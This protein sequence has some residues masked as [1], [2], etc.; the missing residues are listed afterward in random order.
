MLSRV[1]ESLFWMG[2][3]LERT[4]HLARYINVEYFS[5]LDGSNLQ[6]HDMA[7]L[8]IADMI[9]LPKPDI[10]GSLNEEEVLVGAALD[11][12]NPVSIL[13]ALFFAREKNKKVAST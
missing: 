13:S 2:R 3:Y 12:H 11:E 6:Q 7:I 10:D 1:A 5:S 4:E 9:G 8:S